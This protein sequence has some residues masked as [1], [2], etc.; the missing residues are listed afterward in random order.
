MG[1]TVSVDIDA[2]IATVTLNRP[3]KMNAVSL[4]MFADLAEVGDR[5]G[6]DS[7]VRVVVLSGSGENFCAG[8]DTSIFGAN[9]PGIEASSMAPQAP[10]PANFFQRAAYVWREVPVPVICSIHGVAFGAGLQIAL[11]ADIR[12]ATPEARLS[13]MEAKWGIIPDMAISTT[14]RNIVPLDKI[15]ELAY[16]ARVI[17][18][19]EAL[20]IGLI[21]QV[22]DDPLAAAM[23]LAQEI[24]LRSPSAVRSMKQLFDAGWS[25]PDAEALAL[26]ARLQAA[27]L[28]GE[29]QR[30]AV[31]A[32]IEKRAPNFID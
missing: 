18:A 14:A 12:Y 16:T 31:L 8:I 22:H 24:S 7:S 29:N 26:E 9:G 32:T 4:E 3:D 20:R 23:S 30:E 5:L 21:T 15:R 6:A 17:D 10:S 28:G 25:A 19:P 11:G 27:L 13:I 1:S 2:H